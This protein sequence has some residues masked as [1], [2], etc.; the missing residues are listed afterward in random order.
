VT[1]AGNYKAIDGLAVSAAYARP[2]TLPLAVVVERVSAENSQFS[3]RSLREIAQAFLMVFAAWIST[4]L[5]IRTL[6]RKEP[7]EIED[8]DLKFEDQAQESSPMLKIG[9]SVAVTQIRGG[10]N[11]LVHA[12]AGATATDHAF[13]SSRVETQM[14]DE[15]LSSRAGTA[16]EID[17]R[18]GQAQIARFENEAFQDALDEVQGGALDASNRARTVRRLTDTAHSVFNTPALFFTY[19][20]HL[21]NA[22]LQAHSGFDDRNLPVHR[23]MSFPVTQAILDRIQRYDREGRVASLADDPALTLLLT[24]RLGAQGWDAWPNTS[25]ACG[26]I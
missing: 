2:G 24:K 23:G 11:A 10:A 13:D 18:L 4:A 14:L 26:L 25:R 8:S 20:P 1:G 6:I 22:T 15:L 21:K 17:Q 19:L 16:N 12:P 3:F 7:R 9:P 5:G